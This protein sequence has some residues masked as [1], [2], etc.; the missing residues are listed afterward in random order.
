MSDRKRLAIDVRMDRPGFALRVC[1]DVELEGVT[2]LFGPSG[3]GKT[4][5]LRIIAGLETEA[6]GV[7]RFGANTWQ[8]SASAQFCP[9]WR[10]PV[11][12]VFQD[13]RLFPHLDVAGNLLF[14]DRRAG[15]DTS[16]IR[17]DDVLDAFELRPLL[18]RSVE[19]LSGGEAQRVAIARTLLTRP[20]L[21]LLDEPLAGLDRARKR[22]ILPY[23]ENL[24][25]RFGVPAIYVSHSVSEIA[26]L[27]D[28]V[29]VMDAGSIAAAGPTM[30]VLA[31]EEPALAA[32]SFEPVA[33]LDV[34]VVEALPEQYLTR[35]ELDGQPMTVPS[36]AEAS[37]GDRLR[38]L[39]NSVDV[40]LATEKPAG[41]SVRN[42]LAGRIHAI[43]MRRG[44]AFANVLIDVGSARLVARL[45]R[46]AIDEMA[47][48]K[49]DAVYALIKTASFERGA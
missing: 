25:R 10:R 33:V 26:R 49:G 37:P 43:E 11:G 30:T 31:S 47:I 4:T 42:V 14:A 48:G 32:L 21:L 41:L 6:D 39:V 20:E 15:S 28:E 7:V 1:R 29:L 16:A 23:L 12:Y 38:L 40:V 27:T 3:G 8:D 19:N 34:T 22:D 5:L 35:V 44:T 9:A 18:G 36:V 17:F 2:G 45:T 24:P 13:T 46:H